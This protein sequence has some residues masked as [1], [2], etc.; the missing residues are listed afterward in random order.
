MHTF[1]FDINCIS[2]NSG[3]T[4]MKKKKGDEPYYKQQIMWPGT[5]LH[6]GAF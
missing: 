1:L 3:M 4:H 6:A 2:D 5:V